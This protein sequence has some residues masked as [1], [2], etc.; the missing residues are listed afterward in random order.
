MNDIIEIGPRPYGWTILGVY[1]SVNGQ[2]KI[3]AR[4]GSAVIH[5]DRL[6]AEQAQAFDPQTYWSRK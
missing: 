4:R 3:I 2:Y 5:A 6:T 1:N